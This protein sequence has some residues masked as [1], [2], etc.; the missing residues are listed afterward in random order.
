MVT[1]C[2]SSIHAVLRNKS[3]MLLWVFLIT[4]LT[5]IAFATAFL[6]LI[7]VMPVL[8]YASWHGYRETLDASA[9]PELA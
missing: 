2:A 7:I 1:A 3:T 6:G 9:W 8:A 4:M 5:L